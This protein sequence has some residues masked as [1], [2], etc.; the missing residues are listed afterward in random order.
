MSDK[1]NVQ[2]E[3]LRKRL[4]SA[5]RDNKKLFNQAI[6]LYPETAPWIDFLVEFIAADKLKA[7]ELAELKLLQKLKDKRTVSGQLAREGEYINWKDIEYEYYQRTSRRFE[8]N[9]A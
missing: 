2:D 4:I 8:E 1:T 9:Q 3:E 5:I 7:V 6:G